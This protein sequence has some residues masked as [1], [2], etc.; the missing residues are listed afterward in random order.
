MIAMFG[1]IQKLI[2]CGICKSRNDNRYSAIENMSYG[3][4]TFFFVKLDE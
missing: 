1:E 4:L 2:P 3:K